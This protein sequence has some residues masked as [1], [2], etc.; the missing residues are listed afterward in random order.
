[1]R[2]MV[3]IAVVVGVVVALVVASQIWSAA[4]R[5]RSTMRREWPKVEPL[6]DE[7]D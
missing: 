2:S 4:A 6:S 3:W 7:D 1:M 5:Y